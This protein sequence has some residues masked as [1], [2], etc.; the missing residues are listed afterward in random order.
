MIINKKSQ[1]ILAIS[2]MCAFLCQN[3]A[4]V[5]FGTNKKIP[6][7]SNPLGAKVIVD[8]KEMGFT[9]LNLRLKKRNSHIIRI[10][11]NGYKALYIIINRKISGTLVFSILGNYWVG[12]FGMIATVFLLVRHPS[13]EHNGKLIVGLLLAEWSGAVL[14]D[15]ISGANYFLS[16]EELNVTLTK[17]EGNSLPDFILIDAEKFQ[18]IKW[19]RIKRADFDSDE[20]V[21]LD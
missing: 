6:V 18:N 16:P 9:P 11:E 4:T 5:I 19:I 2:I 10:E 17:I 14:L 1:I 12:Y 21:N 8:G 13:L 3:C 7:T 20:I 15:F